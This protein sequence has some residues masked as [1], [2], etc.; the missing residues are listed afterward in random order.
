MKVSDQL[1]VPLGGPQSRSGH[2]DEINS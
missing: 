1:R 2:G